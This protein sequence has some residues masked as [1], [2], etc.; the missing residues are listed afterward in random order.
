MSSAQLRVSIVGGGIGGLAAASALR[1]RGVAATV[2]EQADALGEIGAGVFMSPN[3][4]RNIQRLGAGDRLAAT[5]G[6]IGEGSQYYRMDGTIVGPI[7]TA[8]SFGNPVGA[9]HRAD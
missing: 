9:M 5:I 7:L 6:K 4:L 1:Q 8:D 2:F 3:S